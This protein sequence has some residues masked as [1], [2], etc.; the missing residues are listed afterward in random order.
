[1]LWS[2]RHHHVFLNTNS[3]LNRA[4]TDL[5]PLALS[6]KCNQYMYMYK[7][8]VFYI[9]EQSKIIYYQ[10]VHFLKHNLLWTV[11]SRYIYALL[12]YSVVYVLLYIKPWYSVHTSIGDYYYVRVRDR[13]LSLHAQFILHSVAG[14]LVLPLLLLFVSRI[15]VLGF[16][17]SKHQY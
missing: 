2:L 15:V 11:C 12:L 8:S 3:L 5:L 1:M 16:Y 9:Y 17:F 13:V 7:Y 4:R 6:C 10:L 14:L